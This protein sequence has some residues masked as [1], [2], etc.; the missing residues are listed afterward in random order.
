VS[1]ALSKRRSV[2]SSAG[3]TDH[4]RTRS[5]S[6]QQAIIAEMMLTHA[7]QPKAPGQTRKRSIVSA[8]APAHG[9]CN[10]TTCARATKDGLEQKVERVGVRGGF[11]L[12]T[13][14]AAVSTACA[15]RSSTRHAPAS[16]ADGAFSF[17]FGEAARHTARA[18]LTRQ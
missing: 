9:D 8:P 13:A 3:A 10:R 2:E 14:N 1:G 15:C 17:S 16:T 5:H 11:E 7:P 4:A 12:A 6:H 18:S